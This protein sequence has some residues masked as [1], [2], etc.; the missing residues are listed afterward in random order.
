M[1]NT[2]FKQKIKRLSIASLKVFATILSA[3]LILD[4]V[5]RLIVGHSYLRIVFRTITAK[6]GIPMWVQITVAIVA[7]FLIVK[8]DWFFKQSLNLKH[9]LELDERN[10]KYK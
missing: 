1:R 4:S 6:Y 7:I 10:R 3:A 9:S 5:Y 8:C 2:K